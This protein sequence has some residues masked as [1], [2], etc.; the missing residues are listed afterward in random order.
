MDLDTPLFEGELVYLAPIKPDQDAEIESRWTHDAEFQRMLGEELIRPLSPAQIKKNYAEIEKEMDEKGTQ[1]YFAIRHLP[2]GKSTAA[3]KSMDQDSDLLLGFAKL[4]WIAWNHGVGSLS[5]GIGSPEERGKG[6]GSDALRLLLGYAFRK[7]NFFRVSTTI[8]E[9]NQ[10]ALHVS[11]KAGFKVEAR[12]R[13]AI[14][15]LGR[16]WDML[17]L[18]LLRKEWQQGEWGTMRAQS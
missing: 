12:R 17:H 1:F 4:D 11:A 14:H 8:P 6:Y 7:L 3:V 16:R 2:I 15:R 5:L 13:E 10:V 18:G 9:Y